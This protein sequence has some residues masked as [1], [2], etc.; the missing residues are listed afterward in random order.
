[1]YHVLSNDDSSPALAIRQQRF[2]VEPTPGQAEE[3]C[4][5]KGTL[6]C[7]R[8]LSRWKYLQVH[9][10]YHLTCHADPPTVGIT[11]AHA[12]G[13]C[14]LT[15][16][17]AESY[18]YL[19]TLPRAATHPPTNPCYLTYTIIDTPSFVPSTSHQPHLTSLPLC[20]NPFR[21]IARTLQSSARNINRPD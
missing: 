21:I 19:T 13:T 2:A 4:L 11:E 18:M 5:C 12:L 6:P 10:P 17:K 15:R 20:V 9:V 14:P 3:P 16:L 7:S 1:M 8:W